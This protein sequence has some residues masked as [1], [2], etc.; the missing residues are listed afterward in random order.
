MIDFL[1]LVNAHEK[2]PTKEEIL[3]NQGDQV[4]QSADVNNSETGSLGM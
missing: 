4:A 3:N 1:L 2:P